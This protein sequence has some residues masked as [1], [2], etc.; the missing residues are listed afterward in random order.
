MLDHLLHHHLHHVHALFHHSLPGRHIGGL[1]ADTVG[2]D[3]AQAAIA[4]TSI[5]LF[6]L[7]FPSR[8]NELMLP[9]LVTTGSNDLPR[10]QGYGS[11][12]KLTVNRRNNAPVSSANV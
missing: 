6:I 11:A 12:N 9:L 1:C 8:L 2:A 3:R 4:A 10:A 7:I 5:E